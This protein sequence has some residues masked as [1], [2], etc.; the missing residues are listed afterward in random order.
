MFKFERRPEDKHHYV[1]STPTHTTLSQDEK[2]MLEAWASSAGDLE[3]EVRLRSQQIQ[4]KNERI[5]KLLSAKFKS[6][7][8]RP[9]LEVAG[10]NEDVVNGEAATSVKTKTNIGKRSSKAAMA[11]VQAATQARP[12]VAP[13]LGRGRS[14]R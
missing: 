8:K 12:R 4:A 1:I 3:E 7:T 6:N 11:S 2:K 13:K 5:Q 9:K 10:P 14:S